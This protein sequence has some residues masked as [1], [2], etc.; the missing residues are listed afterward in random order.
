MRVEVDYD[1]DSGEVTCGAQEILISD[2]CTGSNHHGG[3][4]MA[5]MSN[6]DMV[7]AVGD[8]SKVWQETRHHIV[9]YHISHFSPAAALPEYHFC[10]WAWYFSFQR[11]HWS[12]TAAEFSKRQRLFLRWVACGQSA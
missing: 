6:G 1:P 5:F 8:M 9:S 12:M 3:G 10:V 2:W 4:G 7:L 11:Y